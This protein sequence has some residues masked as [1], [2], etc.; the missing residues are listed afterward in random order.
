MDIKEFGYYVEEHIR[1]FLPEDRRESAV[2][3]VHP[4]RSVNDTQKYGLTIQFDGE[5]V[6]PVL[7]LE[8]AWR[9]Y[10]NGE[11]MKTVLGNLAEKYM[12]Y[13]EF[14][15]E[16]VDASMEYEAVKGKVVY[17][18]LNGG[19]NRDSLRNRVYADIGQGLVK[20]YAIYQKLRGFEKEGCI[21]I[22][23]DVMKCFAYDFE[24]IQ[25]D[26]EENTPRI[27][28]AEFTSVRQLL[29]M[30]QEVPVS[31]NPAEIELYELTN[32]LAYRGAGA[33]FYP[34]MQEKIGEQLGRNYFVLPSSL[35]EVLI[36]PEGPKVSAWMLE[37]DMRAINRK[38]RLREEFLSDKVL[39]YDREKGQL[40]FA[41]PGVPGLQ[42]WHPKRER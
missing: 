2:C 4:K 17:Q 22:T 3:A 8:N 36:V 19:A 5:T 39:F 38:A 9:E 25:K 35:H 41:Q 42:F 40:K 20:V 33:L 7:F 32:T 11:G 12:E 31:K 1:D 34:G 10:E 27:F 15:K 14:Q 26:A 21:S 37:M 28:P 24:E 6:S 29:E 18:V 23:H 13:F 16:I 30:A